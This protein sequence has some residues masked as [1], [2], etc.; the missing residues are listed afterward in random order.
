MNIKGLHHIGLF[1]KDLE[2]SLQFYRDG[3]GGKVLCSFPV[4][5]LEKLIYLVDLGNNAVIELIPRGTG[6]EE[7]NPHWV[8]LALDTDDARAAYNHALK[9]GARSKAEPS[10]KK[11]GSMDFCNAFVLGPDGESIEFYEGK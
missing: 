9:A 5:N 1:V 2:K 10:D 7:S 11:F 8:H 4:P 6:A 3:L